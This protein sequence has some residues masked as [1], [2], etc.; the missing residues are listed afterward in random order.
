MDFS[1]LERLSN[2]FGISGR[3]DEV[4]EIVKEELKGLCDEVW[5]DNLGSVI[6]HR[7][8]SPPRLVLDA[9][10]DEVGFMVNHIDKEGF[11]RVL[12]VG[13][14]DQRVFYAQRVKI[15]GRKLIKGVVGSTPPHL[16]RGQQS[17]LGRVP[18]IEDCFIDTGLPRDVV[19]KNV[20]VG[21][22]VGFDSHFFDNGE[23][24][25]GKAFDD[26]IGV[27]AMI[28]GL[29][30]AKES[31]A[32]LYLVGA[33]QEEIGVRGASASAFSVAP[34]LAIALEGTIAN[35]CPGVPQEKR[36][37]R[38]GLGPELRIMDRTMLADRDL[39]DYISTLGDKRGIP[40]QLIVKK[41]GST[42]ARAYQIAR[43]GVKAA[44]ISCPVRYIH[45]P[46]GIA[47]QADVAATVSRVT[48]V[49]EEI[50][51]MRLDLHSK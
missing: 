30:A 21:D 45:S 7:K 36:L 16:T 48:A 44:A 50:G 25:F 34:D 19:L 31:S 5:V 15:F 11:V 35:D 8:G 24:L 29:K 26:R 47:R 43:A 41:A 42:D 1:L 38:H 32:D 39:V 27:F 37:A 49:I 22:Y 9:H 6:G 46:V 17:E 23:S 10:I 33:V 14:V 13:G 2:A 18:E 51:E 20:R 3:E 12:P 40:Y 4:R 28:E